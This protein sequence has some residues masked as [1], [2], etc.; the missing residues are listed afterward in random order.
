MTGRNQQALAAGERSLALA[1]RLGMR[2][3]LAYTT[4][5]LA[6]LYQAKADMDNMN[7]VLEIA[8]PLWRELGNLPMLTDGLT[9][10]AN[11]VVF[12]GDFDRALEISQEA[13][14]IS[15]SLNNPWSQSFT[16]FTP[17]FVHWFRMEISAALDAMGRCISLGREVGFVGGIVTMSNY[18]AQLL[19]DLGQVEMAQQ[20]MQGIRTL[21]ERNIPLFVTAACAAEA[22]IAMRA[23]DL[24][25]AGEIL[26]S[27]SLDEP[28][29]D[30]MNSFTLENGLCEYLLRSHDFEKLRLFA[31]QV[32]AFLKARHFAAFLPQFLYR[33]AQAHYGLGEIDP[34][35]EALQEALAICE[36]SSVRC[37]KW[38]ILALQ[39]EIA[40]SRNQQTTAGRLRQQARETVEWIANQIGLEDLKSTFLQIPELKL[41]FMS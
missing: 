32:V 8:I 13:Q 25:K 11:N 4:N 19:L 37:K 5:D 7:R 30:L 28:L 24:A 3:Q 9:S 21:A 18:Q 35:W 14:A 20:V 2:E 22:L 40:E 41:V 6:Y 39:A 27:F 10:Y 31:G 33:Q 36:Q 1:Q 15:N 26:G 23:G 29:Y 16:L 34:A 38:Q 12:L 17:S